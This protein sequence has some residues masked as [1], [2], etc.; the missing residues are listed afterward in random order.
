MNTTE[1]LVCTN[2][3]HDLAPAAH[4][5]AHS[6]GR[7]DEHNTN[8]HEYEIQNAALGLN[9]FRVVRIVPDQS[10]YSGELSYHG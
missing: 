5:A 7:N 1:Q 9:G 10:P 6:Y 4:H 3:K 2:A 8:W